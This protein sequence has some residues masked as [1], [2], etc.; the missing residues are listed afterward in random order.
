VRASS[1]TARECAKAKR[2]K[3]TRK[4]RIDEA[5]VSYLEPPGAA[6]APVE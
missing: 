5:G 3:T 4:A 6:T 1:E 2:V